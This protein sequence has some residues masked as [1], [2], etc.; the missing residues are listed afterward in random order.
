MS[1]RVP[2]P[3]REFLVKLTDVSDRAAAGWGWQ[4][5]WLAGYAAAQAD[6]PPVDLPFDPVR[7]P[8]A[9]VKVYVQTAVDEVI[10]AATAIREQI[11][12]DLSGPAPFDGLLKAVERLPESKRAKA[13]SP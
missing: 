6:A 5:G 3:P 7:A 4:A 2:L 12:R 11:E 9:V 10:R 1:A 8:A 13:A